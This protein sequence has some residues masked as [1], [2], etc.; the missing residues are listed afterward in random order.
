MKS[1]D[2]DVISQEDYI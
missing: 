2:I 1:I